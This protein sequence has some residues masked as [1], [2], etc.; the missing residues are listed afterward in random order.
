MLGDNVRGLRKAKGWTQRE[1]AERIGSTPSYVN[2]VEMGKV[3]PS[4]G[5]LDRVARAL[6]C[7]LDRLVATH[8][9]GPDVTV[10]DKALTERVRLIES[11]DETDRNAL[12]HMI[13]TMLTKKRVLDLLS[14]KAATVGG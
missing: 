9:N 1:L 14:G 3:N 2:R 8:P 6:D 11:L 4:V 12:L 7:P 13:D 10:R 5:V